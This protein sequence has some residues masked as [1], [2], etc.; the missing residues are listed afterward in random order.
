MLFRLWE[1]TEIDMIFTG[2]SY[3][4]IRDLLMVPVATRVTIR[5]LEARRLENCNMGFMW[6]CTGNERTKT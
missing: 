1:P 6:P 4:V 5:P 2:P 3:S